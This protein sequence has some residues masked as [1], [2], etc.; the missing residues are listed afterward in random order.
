VIFNIHARANVTNMFGNLL[1]GVS[2]KD[3]GHI[4]VSARALL[5]AIWNVRTDLIFNK[6]SFLS[7]LQVVPL[8]THWIHIWS[9]IQPKDVRQDMK[10]TF[11][12]ILLRCSA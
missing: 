6:I 8:V 3:K 4:R 9:Y 12:I 10:S 5:W 11:I 2:M 1:N 7:F